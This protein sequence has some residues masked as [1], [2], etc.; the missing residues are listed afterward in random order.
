VYRQVDGFGQRVD[1]A[2][3]VQRCGALDFAMQF[4]GTERAGLDWINMAA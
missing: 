2:G 1:L 3:D 4:D